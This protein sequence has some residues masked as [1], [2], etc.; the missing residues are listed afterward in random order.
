MQNT[1][2]WQFQHAVAWS[3][4]FKCYMYHLFESCTRTTTFVPIPT[5]SRGYCPRP[6]PIPTAFKISSL[7]PSPL[8]L[9]P[10]PPCS[11]G[12]CPH[13]RCPH[14]NHNVCHKSIPNFRYKYKHTQANNTQNSISSH[15]HCTVQQQP[16]KAVCSVRC[17]AVQ[18]DKPIDTLRIQCQLK[19]E[20]GGVKE[21]EIV[22]VAC[23]I[24]QNLTRM[25]SEHY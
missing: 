17:E 6:H 12:Y 19:R 4:R 9:S 8:K 25:I 5:P 14:I 22:C 23:I 13:S 16:D 20:F 10:F 18:E 24:I 7:S 2:S 11:R 15:S 21:I 1:C 3:T